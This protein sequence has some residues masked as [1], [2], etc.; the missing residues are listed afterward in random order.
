MKPIRK[1]A[2]NKETL[3]RLDP[4]QRDNVRD[5]SCVESCYLV[6]CEGGCGISTGV[7][8]D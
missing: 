3:G 7:K 2:L 1:L 4:R 8:G 5:F 6:S